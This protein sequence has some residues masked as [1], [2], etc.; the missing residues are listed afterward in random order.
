MRFVVLYVWDLIGV[1]YVNIKDNVK[2]EYD[3]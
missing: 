2:N 1:N 3:Y